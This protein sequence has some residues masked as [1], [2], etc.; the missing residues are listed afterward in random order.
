[1]AKDE[2]DAP[3]PR[4]AFE[5]GQPLDLMSVHEIDETI[6]ALREEIARLEAARAA[7]AS[8]STAAEE[9]FKK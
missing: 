7:K 3:R 4:R 5:I 6:A 8:A 1:V 9:F 2:D